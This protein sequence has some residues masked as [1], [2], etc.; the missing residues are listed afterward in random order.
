MTALGLH[1]ALVPW[2]TLQDGINAV[3]RM[4][5]L[6]CFIRAARTAAFPR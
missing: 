2:A 4:L 1:P 5:P 3:R 6:V